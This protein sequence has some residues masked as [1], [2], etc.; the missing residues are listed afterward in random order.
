MNDA[1][2]LQLRRRMERR[3]RRMRLVNPVMRALLSLPFPTPLSR[4]L[5]LVTLTGRKT[6]RTYLQPLSY[7]QDGN[8]LLTPGGGRWKLNLREGVPVRV[9]LLGHDNSALPHIIREAGD[10]AATVKVMAQR[11]AGIAAFI[12]FADRD[13]EVDRAAMALALARGFCIVRW[14]LQPEQS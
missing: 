5:M 7:T 6:G 3:A 1:E 8:T 2:A 13:G 9:R 11:S 4:R 10:V 12:P 14:Q